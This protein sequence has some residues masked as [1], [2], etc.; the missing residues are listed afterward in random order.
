[1]CVLKLTVVV[2]SS[3]V[4]PESTGIGLCSKQREGKRALQRAGI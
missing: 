4:V 2:L 1:M 3:I